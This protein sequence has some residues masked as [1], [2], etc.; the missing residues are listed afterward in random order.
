MSRNAW[1]PKKRL[2]RR[3][4]CYGFKMDTN[5]STT[6]FNGH[7]TVHSPLFSRIFIPLF[8]A[9]TESWENWTPRPH[10]PP[11]AF[12]TRPF[13]RVLWKIERPWTVY[14]GHKRHVTGRW[15]VKPGDFHVF[16]ALNASYRPN[17]VV[18]AINR[19]DPQLTARTKKATIIL[20]KSIL[21]V[22]RVRKRFLYSRGTPS[23]L[24]R[25]SAEKRG[26]ILKYLL[27]RQHLSIYLGI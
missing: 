25:A 1:H 27:S 4:P 12:H 9:R 24:W 6:F 18:S 14:N 15:Q 26:V 13:S 21:C 17:R 10:A 11:R 7:W 16:L 20:I 3:L 19:K 23:N 8:I 2:R 22:W 5:Y